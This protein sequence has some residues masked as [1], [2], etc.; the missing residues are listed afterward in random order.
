MNIGTD[1]MLD[2]AAIMPTSAAPAPSTKAM[3]GISVAVAPPAMLT[4]R[5]E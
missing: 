5:K 1:A 3:S 4:G 2:E